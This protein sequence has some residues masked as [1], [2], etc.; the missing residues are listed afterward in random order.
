VAIAGWRRYGGRRDPGRRRRRRRRRRR[1]R[2]R[3]IVTPHELT[4]GSSGRRSG[5]GSLA[6]HLHRGLAPASSPK[7]EAG[8]ERG[9]GDQ[10]DD[11]P[12]REPTV[13][14]RA[15]RRRRPSRI[16]FR[17]QRP[18]L[19][20]Q[21]RPAR[22]ERVRVP[23]LLGRWAVRGLLRRRRSRPSKQQQTDDQ[24]NCPTSYMQASSLQAPEPRRK[25]SRVRKC[26]FPQG[27]TQN[28][29]QRRS[30]SSIDRVYGG[31]RVVSRRNPDRVA[32]VVF[33]DGP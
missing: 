2:R 22:V 26:T 14:V 15:A 12:G 8:N 4:L 11:D 6:A 25:A 20:G 23:E 7:G 32:A 10:R 18:L 13:I 1:A 27:R 3:R 9:S 5:V 29:V 19:H 16:A 30:L 33:G 31:P 24:R 17:R 28:L 21:G